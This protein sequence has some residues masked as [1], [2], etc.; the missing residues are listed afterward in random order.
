VT[1]FTPPE[2]PPCPA[3]GSDGVTRSTQPS[4]GRW[5]CQSPGCFTWF[6]GTTD[7]WERGAYHR[8]NRIRRGTD[9]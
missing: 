4:L 7:E 1:A 3:C 2:V 9:A 8:E 6:A 5:E